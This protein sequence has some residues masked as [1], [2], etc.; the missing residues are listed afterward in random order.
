MPR[1]IKCK[2]IVQIK[3]SKR[4]RVTRGHKV[5]IWSRAFRN[6][7]RRGGYTPINPRMIDVATSACSSMSTTPKLLALSF[8]PMI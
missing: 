7:E 5:D 6:I 4:A 1:K 8:V 3:E 2:E